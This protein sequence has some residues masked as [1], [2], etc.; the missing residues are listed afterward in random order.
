VASIGVRGSGVAEL[1]RLLSFTSRRGAVAARVWVGLQK[2]GGT[3]GR[4]RGV[5]KGEAGPRRAGLREGRGAGITAE[6]HGWLLLRSASGKEGLPCGVAVSGK[7]RANGRP[8][9]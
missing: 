4:A 6:N 8:G 2:E 9:L 1:L 7:E 3:R 5:F